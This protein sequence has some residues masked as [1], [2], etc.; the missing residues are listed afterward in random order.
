MI[1]FSSF[2]GNIVMTRKRSVAYGR[3]IIFRSINR[4]PAI[5]EYLT[6]ARIKPQ[7]KYQTGFLLSGGE[8][9]H[10]AVIGQ[11]LPQPWVTTA[12]GQHILLDEVLGTG[13]ALLRLHHNPYRAFASLKTDFWERLG[14]RFVCVQPC[15]SGKQEQ[16]IL[17]EELSWDGTQAVWGGGMPPLTVVQANDTSFADY[18]GNLFVVVRPDRYVLG[19]FREEK[20]DLFE[21]ALQGLLQSQM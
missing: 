21:A 8:R 15:A 18:Y 10:N 12:Q 16:G 5:R 9:K 11:M 4:V 3:D 2:L 13:F 14:A 7:P 1:R 20:A 6:E 17:H 19:V